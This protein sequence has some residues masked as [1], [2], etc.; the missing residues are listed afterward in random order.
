M[1]FSGRRIAQSD[2]T[3]RHVEK[4]FPAEVPRPLGLAP[5]IAV[6]RL[7]PPMGRVLDRHDSGEQA[8]AVAA[9]RAL[10]LREGR[11][12][13]VVDPGIEHSYGFLLR[14]GCRPA[15]FPAADTQGLHQPGA[16]GQSA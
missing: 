11:A 4:F 3:A 5:R 9:G 16:A 7:V 15:Q 1:Q 12:L 14:I 13:L 2:L 8:A 6:T 10:S